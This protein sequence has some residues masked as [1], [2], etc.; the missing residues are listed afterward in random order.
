MAQSVS[1]PQQLDVLD[2]DLVRHFFFDTSICPITDTY[3]DEL[4]S[5][6]DSANEHTV[7]QD[8]IRNINQYERKTILNYQRFN[9]FEVASVGLTAVNELL[10]PPIHLGGIG[11][12]LICRFLYG[13]GIALVNIAPTDF[14]KLKRRFSIQDQSQFLEGWKMYKIVTNI[15]RREEEN[16]IEDNLR[17][18]W[19]RDEIAAYNSIPASLLEEAIGDTSNKQSLL[20]AASVSFE[21]SINSRRRMYGNINSSSQLSFLH[22][23]NTM[24][25]YVA[26]RLCNLAER[27]DLAHDLLDY[28]TSAEDDLEI[29]LRITKE[30]QMSYRHERICLPEWLHWSW[31]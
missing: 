28:Q 10:H 23:S 7:A 17:F 14:I 29:I 13:V 6:V 21:D 1:A 26:Y 15:K 19:L 18:D 9:H 27:H 16:G 25:V 24:A 5:I 22:F 4:K 31:S 3:Q 30:L 20:Y 2:R 12:L 8:F 11:I